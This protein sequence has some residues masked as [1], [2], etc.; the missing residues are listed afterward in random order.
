MNSFE[1]LKNYHDQLRSKVNITPFLE[2]YDTRI[3]LWERD[4]ID[5]PQHAASFRQLIKAD[6]EAKQR[7]IEKHSALQI[8]VSIQ[9]RHTEPS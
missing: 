1:K 4:I 7:M 3:A 5:Q 9:L 8:R 2:W 6:R